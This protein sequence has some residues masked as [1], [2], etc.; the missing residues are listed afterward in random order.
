M[1]G[2][3][4]DERDIVKE[5]V[6]AELSGVGSAP[7]KA[8]VQELLLALEAENPTPAPAT[9]PLL[10][11]KWK[12]LY[13][14]GA[15]PG[16][17]ALKVVL[18]GAQ[19]VPKSP[20][21]ADTVDVSD[22]FLTIAEQQPRATASVKVRVLSYEQEIKLESKL[23]AESAVRLME[24]YDYVGT[25]LSGLPFSSPLSYK[26]TMLVSYLD[27]EMLV[28]RDSRGRPDVLIRVSAD[29][30]DAELPSEG[31][32]AEVSAEP[33]EATLDAPEVTADAEVAEETADAEVAAETADEEK[34][35][36]DETA[37]TE[38]TAEEKKDD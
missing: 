17:K 15:S 10:N 14:S 6:K 18:K 11:G 25:D 28:V 33:V 32:A 19:A 23:E 16:L 24:T 9:S 30:A 20:S 37:D 3:G 27:E 38:E 5:T 29:A 36:E 31:W 22:T 4:G 2:V 13:A 35:G 12:F 21:G 8:L 1:L 34:V 26:R 7:E